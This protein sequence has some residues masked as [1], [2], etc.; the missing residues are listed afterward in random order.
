M[1]IETAHA[2]CPVAPANRLAAFAGLL[3][4]AVGVIVLVGW[5]FDIALLKSILPGWVS[6][7]ANTA[8]CFILTGIALC[9]TSRLS[10]TADPQHATR[11][12]RLAAAL[13]GL[14]ALIGLLTLSEYAFG[15][16]PGLDQWL[17]VEPAGTV[18]TSSP[19][20]MAPEKAVCFSALALAL[21]LAGASHKTRLRLM[22]SAGISLLVAALTLAA[23]LSYATPVLGAYGWFGSTIMEMHTAI[24][25]ML[26]GVSVLGI[27]WQP[28]VLSWALGRKVTAAFI[29]GVALLATI[30]LSASRAHFQV[31][32]TGRQVGYNEK[33]MYSTHDL[34]F[35]VLTAQSHIR[36][37]VITGDDLFRANYLAAKAGSQAKLELLHR[38]IADSPDQQRLF[39]QIAV[40]L[41]AIREFQQQ[42]IDARQ[43]GMGAD[44]LSTM[45]LNGQDLLKNLTDTAEQLDTLHRQHVGQLKLVADTVSSTSYLI[46]FTG[47]LASLLISLTTI[48]KLNTIEH[49]RKLAAATLRES[50]ENLAITLHS[51]GDAVITTDAS[52]RIVRMNPTAERLTGWLLPD[53]AGHPLTK[54]FC[55]VNATTRQ[56]VA[57]PAQLVMAQGQ[58]VGL[59]NHTVLLAKGGQEYQ[60]ADS[61]API[62]NAAGAIDGV[63]L[64]FSDVTEKYRTEEALRASEAR[65]R[66]I[67]DASLDQIYSYDQENRFTSANRALCANLGRSACEVIGKSYWELGFPENQCREWD[68][69]HRQVYATGSRVEVLCTPMPDGTDHYFEVNLNLVRDSTGA[70]VGIA[71]VNRD[72]T[73]RKQ[74]EHALQ[75]SLKDKQALL[76]EV[77]HRVKNNLQVIISLL[78]LEGRR[79]TQVDTKAVLTE[80]QGRIHSMALLHESLYRTG[81][82]ASVELGSYLRSLATQAFRAQ[83]YSSGSIQLVVDFTPVHVSMDLATPC[84][85]LVNE[86]ISNC[87]KHGF[88]QD[89]SGEVKVE[90]QPVN[91]EDLQADALWRLCVSDNGVGLSPDFEA[92]RKTSL[93]LQLVGDLSRQINGVLAIQSQPDTGARFTLTFKLQPST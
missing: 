62:R 13:S 9:L 89:R 84:G 31:K 64:V 80:M 27:C 69:L 8:V 40:P 54:V 1:Q 23:I 83:S 49:E 15:W 39:A 6:M 59:A 72:I 28:D 33:V 63:V 82:F 50:E 34:M 36:G 45:A 87:L 91:P 65:Y 44:Q 56:P 61:A 77:H 17:F 57:D 52:G 35:E 70:I 78:R 93:G 5:A 79:S 68:E 12:S 67:N 7:K 81:I 51:I 92:K 60:I 30:G 66:F 75:Q 90:L 41:K 10:A 38:L 74:A 29:C 55:I 86:L 11:L 19:G 20:R 24:L 42:V 4:V 46:L 43:S 25:F 73:E 32:E 76:N 88:P 18:G 22:L 16:N 53:A 2:L 26:L 71:G 3:A 47:A 48:F 21:W 58:V 85:L 14:A 37:Y